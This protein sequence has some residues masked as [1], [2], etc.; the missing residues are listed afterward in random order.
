VSTTLD[1]FNARRT[2]AVSDT[3]YTDYSLT[4]AEK[5]GLK[6]VSQL[7]FSM[8]AP[9]GGVRPKPTR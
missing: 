7:P 6:G 5:N 1:S 4:D 3:A 8:K 2:L 9:K